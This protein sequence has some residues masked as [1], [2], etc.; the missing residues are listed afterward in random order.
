L[1]FAPG[2]LFCLPK[3]NFPSAQLAMPSVSILL[4]VGSPNCR[5]D[6]KESKKGRTKGNINTSMSVVVR[7]PI[8]ER[9]STD[10]HHFSRSQNLLSR[11]TSSTSSHSSTR[12][13]PTAHHDPKNTPPPIPSTQLKSKIRPQ[14]IPITAS[15]PLLPIFPGLFITITPFHKLKMVFHRARSQEHRRGSCTSCRSC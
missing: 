1:A 6:G 9:R 4:V 13:L 8:G 11:K 3:R 2:M 14:N 12:Q 5:I 10:Q 15:I 7:Q